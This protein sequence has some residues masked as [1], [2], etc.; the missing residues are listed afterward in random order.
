MKK[1]LIVPEETKQKIIE[2][3]KV[4]K[5]NSINEI[6]KEIDVKPAKVKAVINEFLSNVSLSK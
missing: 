3:W 4:L 5:L 1:V 6:A 2:K